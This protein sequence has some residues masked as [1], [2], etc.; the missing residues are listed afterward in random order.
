[1]PETNEDVAQ[2]MQA[3]GAWFEAMADTGNSVGPSTTVHSDSKVSNDGGSNPAS[4]YTVITAP[5]LDT[6]T[7]HARGCPVFASGGSI[8][9]RPIV[10]M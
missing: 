7:G 10:E 4:G 9:V 8:E 1:M 5:D 2:L 3:W 6:A